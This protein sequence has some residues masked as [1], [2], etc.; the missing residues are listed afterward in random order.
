MKGFTLLEVMVALAIMA[1]VVLTVISSVNYHLSLTTRNNE[2]SVALL[3]ARAKLE[4]LELLD[5]QQ[6]AQGKEGSFE[7]EWPAYSWKAE[8]FPS[9]V[10][11]FKN[12]TVT[13]TWG[14]QRRTLSLEHYLLQDN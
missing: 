3:L 2:E 7:P 6:L 10:P 5:Q 13:V 8:I 12:L 9:P 1:G 11:V 4:E 14:P